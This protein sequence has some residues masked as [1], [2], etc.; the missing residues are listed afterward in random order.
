MKI[1]TKHT[2][3]GGKNERLHGNG[4]KRSGS[5]GRSGS[6]KK[7][8]V[9]PRKSVSRSVVM[10]ALR[11]RPKKIGLVRQTVQ[12]SIPIQTVHEKENLI[13]PYEGCFIKIY[14]IS[15]INYQT[16]TET[17][18]DLVLT[19]WRAFLN[20]L[21]TNQEMQLTLF[22]RN[23]NLRQFEEEVLL[24]ETGDGYDNLRRQ[25]NEVI[26]GRIME[27]KNGI[28]RD[29]YVTLAVHSESVKKAAEIFR[30][31]D[32]DIDKQMK[33]LGSSAKP[34]K[35]EEELEII[36]DI[37][38]IDNRG[39]FLTKTKILNE[40]GKVEEV[41]SFDIDNIRS[42]GLTVNDV[43]GPSS[44][45][46]KKDKL[47]LGCQ[48]AR[49]LRITDIPSILSDEFLIDLTNMPFNMLTTLNV[50]PMSNAEADALINKQLA[51][52]REEKNN[53]QKANRQAQV[54][55]DMIN[56][57]IIED[58]N[59]ILGIRADMR[60]ND[61]HLFSIAI[62]LVVF[63]PDET[64]LQEY[65]DTVISEC[66]KAS[67]VCEVMDEM[68][69]EG[70]LATLPL[71][72]NVLPN[73]RTIKSSSL[74]VM[75]PFS[76][77]EV[78]ERDGICYTM[79]AV[80]KNLIMFNRLNKANY[81]SMVLG[82]SGSGKSFIVKT[83]IVLNFLARDVDQLIIDVEQEYVFTC[84]KLGGQVIPIM[85][86]GQYHINPLDIAGLDYEFDESSALFG[87]T[88]DPILVKVSF[89]MK[90]CETMVNKSWGMDSIQKTLIDEC[91]RDLYK[92]FMRGGK[93]YRAPLPEETPTLN[94]MMDWF[95]RS[96][97]PEARE[98]FYTLKRY[99]GDGSLNIFSEHTNVEINNR[100]VVFDI[101]QVGEELKLM[102]MT[103]IQDAMWSRLRENR[104]ISR[105]TFIYIDEIHLYFAPGQ[106][107]SAQFIASLYKRARKYGGACTG[108]TQNVSDMIDHPVAKKIISECSLVM[109]LN[110][111]SEEA[112]D[113]IKNTLNLSDSMMQY[114]ISAPIGQGIFS[115][116]EQA[117]PFFSRFPKDNDIY[118]LLTSNMAELLE[119]REKERRELLKEKQSE[120]KA[121]YVR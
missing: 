94:D 119:I 89:I 99:A 110:Q 90:L 4:R 59:E 43:V 5:A 93:L 19:K 115:T 71:C 18:Q 50:K 111:Q 96:K 58:E 107:T 44:F 12:A 22:N 26:M 116:G 85:P 73:S 16:S 77:L 118:P 101:S 11:P 113:A 31:V 76:N 33:S 51:F 39:E 86:G 72:V 70:L 41:N 36:H 112:R 74:A 21:G 104:R 100:L 27:G 6:G 38:N 2:D 67:V 54:S 37:F 34:V 40:H 15:N 81:N 79:N 17:E 114:I 108:I 68:Q 3:N 92:P 55:E 30:R 98:L 83:E 56:P 61:E 42:M 13:E 75:S 80:S 45:V 88:V 109:V 32:N 52:I 57:Q 121:G 28:S 62:S 91:L 10:S 23:I 20:S 120:R 49:V 66:K 117:V 46:V 106:E 9:K 102:A 63:A 69:E 35:I 105:Y 14:R 7:N 53:L 25:M 8:A 84:I 47:E 103:I 87:D 82:S 64:L 95:G 48:F 65:T 78:M 24:K 1:K 60:E 97:V 29:A